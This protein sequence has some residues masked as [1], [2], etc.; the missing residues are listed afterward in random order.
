MTSLALTP[1]SS[2]PK[3]G[4]RTSEI[5]ACI[6]RHLGVEVDFI[7]D[8][9]HFAHDL[10][11]DWLDVIELLVLLEEQFA[12]GRVMDE[13]EIEFVGDLIR[14]IETCNHLRAS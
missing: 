6:A 13:T 12:D 9:L 5:R 7:S 3:G 2:T 8:E 11:L 14:H 1:R 4:I 10:G